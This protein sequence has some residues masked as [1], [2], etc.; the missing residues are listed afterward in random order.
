MSNDICTSLEFPQRPETA[1]IF[2]FNI[3]CISTALLY[4]ACGIKREKAFIHT[5]YGVLSMKH[6]PGQPRLIVNLSAPANHGR[7]CITMQG[8]MFRVQR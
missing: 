7:Q 3:H 2:S 4:R 8:V 5:D 1:N 6:R